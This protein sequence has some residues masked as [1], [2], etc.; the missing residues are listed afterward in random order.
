MALPEKNQQSYNYPQDNQYLYVLHNQ[1]LIGE[2]LL[3]LK[4]DTPNGNKKGN[5]A[6]IP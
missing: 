1:L 4:V 2:L 3:H 5:H 6:H